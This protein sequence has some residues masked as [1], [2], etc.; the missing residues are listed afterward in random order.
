MARTTWQMGIASKSAFNTA[1]MGADAASKA[2]SALKS[3]VR[4]T[5]MSYMDMNRKNSNIN[6]NIIKRS[7]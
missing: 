6:S 4:N 5:T 2:N 7:W 1:E 3:E